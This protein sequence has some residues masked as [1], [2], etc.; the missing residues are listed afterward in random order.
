MSDNAFARVEVAA[1]GYPP[2]E[3]PPRGF[4][5]REGGSTAKTDDPSLLVIRCLKV[6]PNFVILVGQFVG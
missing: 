3:V 5:R 4:D 1:K 6:F 2:V